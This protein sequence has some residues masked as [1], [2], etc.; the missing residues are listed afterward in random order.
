MRASLLLT[1]KGLEVPAHLTCPAREISSTYN[2]IVDTGSERS[3]LAWQ[4]AAKA[5]IDIEDLPSHKRPLSGFGGRA[6]AKELSGLFYVT[7]TSDDKELLTVEMKE[8][9]LIWRPSRKKS[10]R[11]VTIPPVSILGR[12]F[13]KSSGFT[14]VVNLSKDFYYFEME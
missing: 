1:E 10:Q 7:L 11:Y 2:F 4:D 13:M 8:G 6:E 14:L 5:G 9:L 12:D 3:L